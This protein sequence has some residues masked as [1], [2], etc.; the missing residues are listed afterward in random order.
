M[1]NSRPLDLSPLG[2]GGANAKSL[3]TSRAVFR[4]GGRPGPEWPRTAIP[5]ADSRLR[6][7]ERLRGPGAPEMRRTVTLLF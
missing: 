2:Q 4:R 7:V 6:R 5:I 1:K 3:L